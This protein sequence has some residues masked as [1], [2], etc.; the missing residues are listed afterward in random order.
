MAKLRVTIVDEVRSRRLKVDLPD[1]AAVE[2]LLPALAKKLGLPPAAYRLTHEATGRALGGDQTLASFGVGEGDALRLAA[3][4][5]GKEVLSL[6]Q[7]IP[8]W[9]WVGIVVVL[10]VAAFLIGQEVKKPVSTP[11]MVAEVTTPTATSAP[12]PRPTATPVAPTSTPLPPTAMPMP[13]STPRPTA[14]PVPPTDTPVP[15]TAT[16]VPMSTPTPLPLTYDDNFNDPAFDGTY[17]TGLWSRI[18][19][20]KGSTSTVE[21]RDGMLI[22]RQTSGLWGS[23]AELTTAKHSNWLLSDLGYVEAR[24]MLD[25]N[26][27]G[28][29][30]AVEVQLTSNDIDWLLTCYIAMCKTGQFCTHP[31]DR[32]VMNCLSFP[33][34]F[35]ADAISVEYNTWHTAR[36]E[37]DPETVTFHM[38]FDGYN[39]NSFTPP[40]AAALKDDSFHVEVGVYLEPKSSAT[41]YIDDVRIGK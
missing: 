7:R 19:G 15:P 31:W 22:V 13:T 1:D 14:T 10:A 12:M 24:L 20:A 36:I 16:P 5:E 21:Q 28:E 4:R 34:Q 32:P 8:V 38:Y 40:N 27:D 33:D 17:N 29:T 26:F 6:W 23:D 3:A 41:G 39:F 35:M 37:V 25:S 2:K 30:A 11:T 9:I 18:E